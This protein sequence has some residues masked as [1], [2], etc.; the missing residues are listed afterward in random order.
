MSEKYYKVIV[1]ILITET[2]YFI[3]SCVPTYK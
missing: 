3:L 2:S 1:A